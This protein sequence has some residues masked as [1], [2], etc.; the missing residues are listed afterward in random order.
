MRAE[1]D[2]IADSRLEPRGP[3]ERGSGLSGLGVGFVGQIEEQSSYGRNEKPFRNRG[4]SIRLC[5][6]RWLPG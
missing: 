6:F 5:G 4:L 2:L 1:T 3:D